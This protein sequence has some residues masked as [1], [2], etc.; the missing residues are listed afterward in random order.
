MFDEETLE[1]ITMEMLASLEY[2]C[3]SGYEIERDFTKVLLEEDLINS[4]EKLN[5]NIKNEQT[6]EVIRL[7]K[8]LDNN[9]TILNNKQFTKYLL[10]GL[11]K[12]MV[13]QNIKQLK[14]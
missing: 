9:N 5:P 6:S 7:I 12:K 1:K 8:N 11:F 14:Y 3:I 13:K 10:E 4:I 2:E